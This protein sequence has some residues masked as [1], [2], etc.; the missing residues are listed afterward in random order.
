MDKIKDYMENRQSDSEERVLGTISVFE[1]RSG[2]GGGDDKDEFFHVKGEAARCGN[3][4]V[5]VPRSMAK[6]IFGI[7]ADITEVMDKGCLKNS[8]IS[9]VVMNVNHG[10]G[11]HAVARTRNKTLDLEANDDGLFV[12]DCRL[13]KANQ[14]CAQFYEDVSEGLLSQMSFRFVID[15]E[16]FDEKEN[17]FH[18]QSIS[19][20]RDVSAVEFPANPE[21]SIV[22]QSRSATLANVAGKRAEALAVKENLSKASSVLD[23]ILSPSVGK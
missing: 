19:R 23:S 13:K 17:C 6:E 2:E 1:Q 18:I 7:D 21:T 20:V 22:S 16:E 4:Y 3:K 10:D 8:D 14:R 11:N 15:K 5:L 9:D 12:R